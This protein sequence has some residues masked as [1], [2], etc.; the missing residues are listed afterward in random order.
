ME[1][2]FSA[3]LDELKSMVTD[4]GFL[5]RPFVAVFPVSGAAVSTV[6][7]LLGSETLSASDDTAA[8]LD[9]LQ[10]DLNEG[11]CWDALRTLRPV[12]V[13]DVAAHPAWPAFS[14]AVLAEDVASIFA[15]PLE[16][17]GLRIGA[18]DLYSHS[19]MKLDYQQTRQAGALAGEVSRQV[20]RRALENIGVDSDAQ[21][22]AFS[23]RVIHQATGMVL[24]QLDLSPDDAHL[25]LQGHAFAA[26]RTVIE[27]AEDVVAR[28]LDFSRQSTGIEA[29]E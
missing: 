25:V 18:V 26:G 9:E 2:S 3:A 1:E 28:R 24:A 14:A 27:V 10:F 7:D 13:P 21:P 4:T 16:Y 22:A 8:R 11:P 15:F 6:G 12:L 20:L 19:P 29:S 23:R 5:S 17:G